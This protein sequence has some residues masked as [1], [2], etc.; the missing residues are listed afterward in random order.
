MKNRLGIGEVRRLAWDIAEAQGRQAK[1]VRKELRE[2]RGSLE[3]RIHEE[4]A[5]EHGTAQRCLVCGNK[6]RWCSCGGKVPWDCKLCIKGR[7]KGDTVVVRGNVKHRTDR[8]CPK[9]RVIAET[10]GFPGRNRS[11]KRARHKGGGDSRRGV[12]RRRHPIP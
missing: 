8:L 7:G 9:H 10:V 6:W 2:M 1:D 4:A 11:E 5:K 12:A 3:E